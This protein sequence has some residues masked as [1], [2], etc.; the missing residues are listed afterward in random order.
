MSYGPIDRLIPAIRSYADLHIETG[1][2]LRSFL[3]NDLYGACVRA[4]L[5]LQPYFAAIVC[6]LIAETPRECWGSKEA[7]QAWLAAR[8]KSSSEVKQ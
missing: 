7:V 6:Y 8:S 1:S 3:E 5:D 4:D 2:F